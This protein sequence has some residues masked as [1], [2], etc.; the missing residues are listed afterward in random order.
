MVPFWVSSF[1]NCS[2]R[3]LLRLFSWPTGGSHGASWSSGRHSCCW[4]EHHTSQ[5]IHFLWPSLHNQTFTKLFIEMEFLDSF[6]FW[7]QLA[8]VT[9]RESFVISLCSIIQV[10]LSPV[11]LIFA[12]HSLQLILCIV[13]W[14]IHL[15]F[16]AGALLA[17]FGGELEVMGSIGLGCDLLGRLGLDLAGLLL[18]EEVFVCFA[19]ETLVSVG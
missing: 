19:V 11:R 12:P 17:D 6:I 2:I 9:M 7:L 3:N 14:V 5:G 10:R 13:N 1:P 16:D 4:E 8:V 15:S 18:G